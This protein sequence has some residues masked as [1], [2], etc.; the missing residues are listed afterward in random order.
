MDRC[1]WKGTVMKLMKARFRVRVMRERRVKRDRRESRAKVSSR[2]EKTTRERFRRTG[3]SQWNRKDDSLKTRSSI[4]MLTWSLGCLQKMRGTRKA[5]KTS[6][7]CMFK[8]VSC[9]GCLGGLTEGTNHRVA[10]PTC[11]MTTSI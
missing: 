7:S 3:S 9:S 4:R 5:T 2:K 11:S 10:P 8:V 6:D 1:R